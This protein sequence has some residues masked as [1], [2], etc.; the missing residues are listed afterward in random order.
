M[1]GRLAR[2]YV[3]Y[4]L[5]LDARELLKDRKLP[6][7]EELEKRVRQEMDEATRDQ[8]TTR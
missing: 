2:A 4:K 5:G 6:S 8:E 7:L 1:S 3:I